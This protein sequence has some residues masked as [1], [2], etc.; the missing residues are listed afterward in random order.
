MNA[1]LTQ[2]CEE[3]TRATLSSASTQ[4][5]TGLPVTVQARACRLAVGALLE[6]KRGI[7]VQRCALSHRPSSTTTTV[8][9][10]AVPLSRCVGNLP[11][12]QA[13]VDALVLPRQVSSCGSID[14][15]FEIARRRC[16]VCCVVHTGHHSRCSRD[17][18]DIA[19]RSARCRQ[20]PVSA[21]SSQ[22]GERFT[23]ARLL[24]AD[25]QIDEK[26]E[27]IALTASDVLS[28]YLGVT[29]Q[30]LAAAFDSARSKAP[31][32]LFVDEIDSLCRQRSAAEDDVSRRIK[33][34]F[35]LQL[36]S[37]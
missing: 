13:L 35:L 22:T 26:V 20:D 18:Q 33:N 3:S 10:S 14:N 29:E 16:L 25:E 4:S 15:L 21:R 9:T 32:I 8:V 17:E 12:K 28:P 5:A 24:N 11:A 19:V 37:K 7:E 30:N 31:A 2:Q 6:Y 23:C 1:G 27:F 34:T 36:D